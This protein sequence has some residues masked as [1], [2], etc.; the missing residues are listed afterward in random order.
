MHD[1]CAF[2]NNAKERMWL[3]ASSQ[4]PAANG[5]MFNATMVTAV[6]QPYSPLVFLSLPAVGLAPPPEVNAAPGA[7]T[8]HSLCARIGTRRRFKR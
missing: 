5:E 7:V 6:L 1:L 2:D 3:R 8:D 4:T